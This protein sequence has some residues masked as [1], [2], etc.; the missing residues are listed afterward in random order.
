MEPDHAAYWLLMQVGMVLGFFTAYPVNVWLIRRGIKEP[1]RRNAWK[2]DP[3]AMTAH[4]HG[5]S[6]ARARSFDQSGSPPAATTAN[7]PSCP[8]RT[9]RR[10]CSPSRRE[11]SDPV[12]EPPAATPPLEPHPRHGPA[13][14]SLPQGRQ[15]LRQRTASTEGRHAMRSHPRSAHAVVPRGGGRADRAPRVQAQDRGAFFLDGGRAERLAD[16]VRSRTAPW[17]AVEPCRPAPP[18][19]G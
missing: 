16:R 7:R 9:P 19:R 6:P 4:I 14:H 15:D 5:A 17:F 18:H 11:G 8:A 10:P 13:G 2:A 12:G 1:M 3:A